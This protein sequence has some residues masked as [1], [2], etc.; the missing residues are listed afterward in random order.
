MSDPS[1]AGADLVSLPKVSIRPNDNEPGTARQI[2]V[3]SDAAATSLAF[4][5]DKDGNMVFSGDLTSAT[6]PFSIGVDDDVTD[7]V[8]ALEVFHTTEA[9]GPGNPLKG[10]RIVLSAETATN[11]REPFASVSGVIRDVTDAAVDGELLLGAYKGSVENL[12]VYV[13]EHGETFVG[14]NVRTSIGPSAGAGHYD[15]HTDGAING[16]LIGVGDTDNA[17]ASWN[18]TPSDS[19]GGRKARVGFLG[20]RSDGAPVAQALILA[21]HVGTATDDL[22]ALSFSV[23][24][25]SGY[26]EAATMTYE[27]DASVIAGATRLNVNRV[28]GLSGGPVAVERASNSDAGAKVLLSVLDVWDG[29]YASMVAAGLES[30]IS[31]ELDSSQ[32]FNGYTGHIGV[33]PVA[34]GYEMRFSGFGVGA[35]RLLMNA[36][37]DGTPA[38]DRLEIYSLNSGSPDP[39]E[40]EN[41]SPLQVL[42]AEASAYSGIDIGSRVAGDADGDRTSGINFLGLRSTLTECRL[43]GIRAHLDADLGSGNYSGKA[44]LFVNGGGG[45]ALVSKGIEVY[46]TGYVRSPGTATWASVTFGA[47]PTYA[48]QCGFDTGTV[49][50]NPAVGTYV[51]TFATT[52]TGASLNS[53]VFVQPNIGGGGG[54]GVWTSTTTLTCYLWTSAAVP[55]DADF[56][57]ICFGNMDVKVAP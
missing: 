23:N 52:M 45:T 26:A 46:S 51:L 31:W 35:E 49:I 36:H 40:T 21:G 16:A 39:F 9:I 15:P 41:L 43:A 20:T 33:A 19:N 2:E 22:S 38:D 4:A 37:F 29:D 8:T 6:P 1:D 32:P 17:I 53:V 12:A 7:R 14:S 57:V 27:D 10:P 25:G 28:R 24:D 3:W 50:T 42:H 55:V 5:I 30:R 13:S 47:P 11:L 44:T 18:T 48:D 34:T 54:R 56:H